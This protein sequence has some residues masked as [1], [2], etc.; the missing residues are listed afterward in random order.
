MAKD[1]RG[2]YT[3]EPP[4]EFAGSVYIYRELLR[5]STALGLI[6]EG[7]F[8]EIRAAEPSKPREGMLVVADGTNWNPGSGKGLYE[9]K[10]GSWSKL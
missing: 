2:L 5:I 6:A 4:G 1:N 9:R 10:N 3:P 8:L 7:R